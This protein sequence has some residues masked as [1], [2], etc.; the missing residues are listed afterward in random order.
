MTR[1]RNLFGGT[2]FGGNL[3]EAASKL[4]LN[5]KFKVLK[6]KSEIFGYVGVGLLAFSV[7]TS[8]AMTVQVKG[9]IELHG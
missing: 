1:L 3:T 2:F 8:V 4:L 7:R 5:S 6:N 9:R